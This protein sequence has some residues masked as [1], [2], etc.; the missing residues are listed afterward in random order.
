MRF[1]VHAPVEPMNFS[2]GGSGA[3]AR[4]R[5]ATVFRKHQRE[6][7]PCPKTVVHVKGSSKDFSNFRF[8]HPDVRGADAGK[9][10][11]HSGLEECRYLRKCEAR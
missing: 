2:L 6:L 1:F 7:A 9:G 4:K 11:A 10:K 3:R 8:R 5:F